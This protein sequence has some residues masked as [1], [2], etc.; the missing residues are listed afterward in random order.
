MLLKRVSLI[1]TAAFLKLCCHSIPANTPLPQSDES[2]TTEFQDKYISRDSQNLRNSSRFSLA[3]SGS[4]SLTLVKAL[5]Q[6]QAPCGDRSYQVKFSEVV[7]KACRPR[8]YLS[9]AAPP[10]VIQVVMY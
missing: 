9:Q 1:Q 5:D 2:M 6:F 8:L 3:G 4:H 10:C 7:S